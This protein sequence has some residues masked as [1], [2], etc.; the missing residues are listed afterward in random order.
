MPI[1]EPMTGIHFFGPDAYGQARTF[2]SSEA[3]GYRACR[4]PIAAVLV[5]RR[6]PMPIVGGFVAAIEYG[7]SSW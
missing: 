1:A 4:E 7:R 5:R 3:M 6:Y 2:F